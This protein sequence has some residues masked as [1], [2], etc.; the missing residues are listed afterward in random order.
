MGKAVVWK[1][2]GRY[3]TD[4]NVK[5]F[6]DRHGFRDLDALLTRSQEDPAWFWGAVE[7][8][9]GLAW[10]EPY[11]EVLDDAK[12]IAWSRWYVGGKTNIA[13]N[14]VDRHAAGAR[15]NKLA[16]VWE[17]EDGKVTRWTYRDLHRET[18]RVANWLR[19]KGVG[20]GDAVGVYMPM[21]PEV[22]AAL[23]A[24][25]KV[26]GLF[27][28]L[29][30][31]FGADAIEKRLADA[32]AK[33]LLT[34]DGFW[35]KGQKVPMKPVADEALSKVPSV[36]HVLVL[37]R[38]GLDVPMRAGRDEGW[39]DAVHGLSAEAETERMDSE[40]PWMVIYTSGTTGRPK[41]S[42]HVHGG[43]LV[44]IAQEVAHQTDL[45]DE[46]L[47]WWFTD[48]GWIMGPWEVVG[49]LAL[50]GSVFLYE[51]APDHPAPD[52]MWSMVER[53][54]VTILG[55]SPTLVRALMRH[56]D[57]PEA[58]AGRRGS[59]DAPPAGGASR[60]PPA[61]FWGH[62]VSSLRILASTGEPW[63]PEPWTWLFEKVGGSRCPIINLSGGTE[64]GACFLSPTPLTPL[65]PCS[66]GHPALGM[67]VAVLDDAGRPVPA[68]TVGELAAT[69]PWPGMT[70]GLWKDPERYIE[71]YWSRWPGI[72]YHGDFASVDEDGAWYLHGRSDDTIK[73]AGK[74]VGPAE[75][76]SAL[77]DTGLVQEAAAVGIPHPVKGDALHAWVILRPGVESGAKTEEALREAVERALGKSFRPA[78]IHVVRDLPRTRNGKIL[79]RGVKAKAMGK[80]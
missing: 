22:V 26:G 45:K 42:V 17:G 41:G 68:G 10:Y 31:G 36:R 7:K 64:V 13:L 28:P 76:E 65:A 63:N 70:R 80:D 35:R 49:G 75:V 9:L 50:G 24:I 51:G 40:D 34:S 58:A 53:H 38:L 19:A 32:G 16:V 25:C 15:R 12:G 23:L 1:P 48:M 69:K 60:T 66:L 46:D 39:V 61:A 78:G 37:P 44:K 30:S 4:A 43:F 71:A 52:R 73:I 27:V 5:G 72:W 3:A 21:V 11:R 77:V 8:D 14:C 6:L 54:G 67:S 20:K 33:A 18:N 47:L 79:R 55:V 56:G 57:G 2:H 74:R 59:A 29:F 62:D